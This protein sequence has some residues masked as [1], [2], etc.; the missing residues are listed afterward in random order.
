MAFSGDG[1]RFVGD[2]GLVQRATFGSVISGDAVTPLPAS[3]YLIL[4]KAAVS[5]FPPN[6]TGTACAAG[7][8]LLVDA[9]VTIIPVVGDVVVEVD[10][11]DLCDVSSFTIPFTADEIDVTT[12]CDDIKKYR[13]GK[14]DMQ[15]TINGVFTAGLSDDV[16]GFLRQFIRMVKQDAE[17]SMDV[18]AQEDKILLGIFYL[19]KNAASADRMAIIAPFTLFGYSVGGEMGAAQSFKSSFRFSPYS[20]DDGTYEVEIEPTFHRWGTTTST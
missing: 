4:A 10:V 12:L 17:T 9:G 8:F 6:T 14:A 20:Y 1:A 18:Y 13:R 11:E 16:D 15:G 5:G 2:D 3:L 19:N 7:D